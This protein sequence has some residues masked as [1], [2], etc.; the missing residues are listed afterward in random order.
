MSLT[1]ARGY[2]L[3]ERAPSRA[4]ISGDA[5]DALGHNLGGSPSRAYGV[6]RS[7]PSP[8]TETRTEAPALG[9]LGSGLAGA[10]AGEED[11]I[12]SGQVGVDGDRGEA[13][14]FGRGLCGGDLVG[15]QLYQQ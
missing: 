5:R 10:A 12:A 6:D 3:V 15:G 13:G 2:G 14:G 1:H 7:R 9:G 11:P 8:G 4:G